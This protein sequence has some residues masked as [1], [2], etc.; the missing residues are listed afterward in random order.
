MP[1]ISRFL[2]IVIFMNFNDHN[3]PHF[4]AKYVDYQITVVIGS[5]V[6]EGKFRNGHLLMSWNGMSSIGANFWIIGIHWPKPVT[7]RKFNL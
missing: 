1:E 7:L 5:G 4:H 2:G 3:P 6:V